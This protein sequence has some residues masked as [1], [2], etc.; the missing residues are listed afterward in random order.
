MKFFYQ[1]KRKKDFLGQVRAEAKTFL[2]E[3]ND[4]KKG[5]QREKITDG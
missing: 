4:E 1:R 3:Y 2:R 5:A